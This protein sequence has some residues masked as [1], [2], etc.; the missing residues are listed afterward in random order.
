MPYLAAGN[1]LV[2]LPRRSCPNAIDFRTLAHGGGVKMRAAF[3]AEGLGALRPACRSLDEYLGRPSRDA[4]VSFLR[5][6]SDPECGP[7][8]LLAVAAMTDHYL[9]RVHICLIRNGA[10][11]APTV[12][13]HGA[14]P[15]ALAP[16][17]GATH[18][19]ADAAC[20]S[21]HRASI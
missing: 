1:Q 2:S 8:Q 21:I 20:T 11:E 7:G 18:A 5:G 15:P 12:N 3:R 19:L 13:S 10:A 14:C 6:R 9:F 16:D 17:A 4:V